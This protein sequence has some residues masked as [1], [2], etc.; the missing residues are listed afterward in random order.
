MK[1]LILSLSLILPLSQAFA[2]ADRGGEDYYYYNLF[3]QT[4]SEAPQYQPFLMTMDN[5]YYD[6]DPN[7]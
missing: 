5:P 2:C 4:L 3:S 7:Q 6:M 1:K